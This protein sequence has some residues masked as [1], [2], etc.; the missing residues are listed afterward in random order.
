M[1]ETRLAAG[2][3]AL[4]GVVLALAAMAVTISGGAG[5]LGGLGEVFGSSSELRRGGGDRA[6][7]AADVAVKA[8]VA[9]HR[10]VPQRVSRP[11]PQQVPRREAV[12]APRP[13]PAPAPVAVPQPAPVAAPAPSPAPRPAPAPPPTSPPTGPRPQPGGTVERVTHDLRDAVAP[14]APLQPVVD[15][16]TG[17]VTQVCALL[18]GCP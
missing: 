18:G 14:V 4:A 17:A 2:R 13:A 3:V 10:V 7:A 16:A 1:T 8:L 15:Q 11:Q 12:A 5:L 6:H 9:S